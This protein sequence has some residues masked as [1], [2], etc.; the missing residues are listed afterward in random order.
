M[1]ESMTSSKRDIQNL[2]SFVIEE[3]FLH[4]IREKEEIFAKNLMITSDSEL[5]FNIHPL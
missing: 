3:I 4:E 1:N 2:E 5:T